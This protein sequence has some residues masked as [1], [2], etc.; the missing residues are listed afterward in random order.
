[1]KNDSFCFSPLNQLKQKIKMR[2][3]TRNKK[4]KYKFMYRFL[5]QIVRVR[6]YK[7]KAKKNMEC[8]NVDAVS[9]LND[10]VYNF[11]TLNKKIDGANLSQENK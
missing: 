9:V 11:K 7:S 4:S 10:H 5:A 6:L 1:M 3:E 8:L 2:L